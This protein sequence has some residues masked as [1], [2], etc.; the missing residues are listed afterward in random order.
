M[1]TNDKLEY[2][3]IVAMKTLSAM[4]ATK[5]VERERRVLSK[6]PESRKRLPDAISMSQISR[7]VGMELNARNPITLVNRSV[8]F[9]GPIVRSR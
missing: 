3:N 8:S 4:M 5:N 9:Y 6:P 7:M 2:E 1:I